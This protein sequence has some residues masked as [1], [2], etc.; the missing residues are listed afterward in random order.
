MINKLLSL[1]VLGIVGLLIL[2]VISPLV[3]SSIDSLISSHTEFTIPIL[4]LLLGIVLIEFDYKMRWNYKIY[5]IPLSIIGGVLILLE[6]V[7]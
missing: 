5:G 3:G 6:Y 7:I 4:I 1:L 2:F